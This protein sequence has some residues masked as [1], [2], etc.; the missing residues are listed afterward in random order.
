MSI[1]K[2]ANAFSIYTLANHQ[3][4]KLLSHGKSSFKEREN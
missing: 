1:W 3:I 2:C 4:F